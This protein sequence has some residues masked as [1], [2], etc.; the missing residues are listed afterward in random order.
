MSKD[1]EPIRPHQ[2]GIKFKDGSRYHWRITIWNSAETTNGD[3]EWSYTIERDTEAGPMV[4]VYHGSILGQG[5]E[6]VKPRAIFADYL[7]YIAGA[8]LDGAQD[9]KADFNMDEEKR[10]AGDPVALL[11]AQADQVWEIGKKLAPDDPPGG[12]RIKQAASELH[13]LAR[14]LE[15]RRNGD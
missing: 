14:S 15:S 12:S 13:G 8:M 9:W 1:N 5:D 10:E 2:Y 4:E 11:R 7:A 3:Y 6:P